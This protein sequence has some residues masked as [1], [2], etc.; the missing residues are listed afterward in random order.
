[1]IY[2]GRTAVLIDFRDPGVE[3]A[4]NGKPLTIADPNK[5]SVKDVPGDQELTI[6]CTGLE[7]ATK[8]SRS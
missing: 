4:V 1:M 6:T 2:L 5:Q 7:T 3:V 8:A